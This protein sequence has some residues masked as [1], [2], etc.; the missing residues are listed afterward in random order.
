MFSYQQ[1][2]MIIEK[3]THVVCVYGTDYKHQNI[4]CAIPLR[5][6]KF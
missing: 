6:P 1:M 2:G 4:L 3:E 5:H